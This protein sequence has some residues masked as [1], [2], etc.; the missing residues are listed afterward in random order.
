MDAL[1][2]LCNLHADGPLTLQR[3]RYA[4]CESLDS[5]VDLS[6]DVLAEV[7][8]G[9]FDQVQTADR[10][11]R[12][13]VLLAQRIDGEAAPDDEPEDGA[14]PEDEASSSS[15]GSLGLPDLAEVGPS[16]EAAA[17]RSVS[18]VLAAW[19]SLDDSTPPATPTRYEIPR[20][21]QDPLENRAIDEAGLEGL[22]PVL[23]NRL[24]EIGVLSLRGLM[25]AS[26]VELAEKLPLAFTRVKRLQLLARR[27][28][29]EIGAPE[30]SAPTSGDVDPLGSAGPFA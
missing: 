3:L 16:A 14:W 2:L 28:W 17:D 24:A 22:T 1:A 27:A 23:A 21:T 26:S 30:E 8:E 12:E 4:G 25:N 10:F 5:L 13:A 19:R 20:P 18:E 29:A 7:L 11:Q 6:P 15:L 9:E